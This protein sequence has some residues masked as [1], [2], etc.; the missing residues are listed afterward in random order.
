VFWIAF[1]DIFFN[2]RVFASVGFWLWYPS[3]LD[4]ALGVANIF[5]L[6]L[7][8][9][10]IIGPLL[11]LIVA[12]QGK[13]SLKTDLLTIATLQLAALV[14][15]LY[16]V[17][18]G[19]PVWIIYSNN[20]FELVQAYEAVI[21]SSSN[22]F[23]LSLNGPVWGGVTDQMPNSIDKGDAYY[24]AEF[25]KPIDEK[26]TINIG[27][28]SHPLVLL[29]RFNEPAKVRSALSLYSGANAFVPLAA[30]QKS[31]VVLINN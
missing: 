11:T 19:R 5:L 31:L 12:K 20:R 7:S 29:N 18:Q 22:Q 3:P 17:A 28:F 21:D 14:Y 6:L 8:I 9:D 16:M 26:M 23:T 25:L 30:K 24:R 15:G 4:K 13:R 1:I 27:A 2:C 10:V